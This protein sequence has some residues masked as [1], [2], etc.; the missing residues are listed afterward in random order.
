MDTPL[1]SK[2]FPDNT[3]NETSTTI[4]LR[5]DGGIDIR[6]EV[7]DVGPY[8]EEAILYATL[9]AAQVSALRELLS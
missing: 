6:I 8:H 5:S 7:Q 2:T 1:E 4:D 9:D 3:D